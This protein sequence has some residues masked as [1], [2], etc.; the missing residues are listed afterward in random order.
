M[1]L[2]EMFRT[3]HF[4]HKLLLINTCQCSEVVFTVLWLTNCMGEMGQEDIGH[5]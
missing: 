5:L 1:I 2:G 4:K 3:C